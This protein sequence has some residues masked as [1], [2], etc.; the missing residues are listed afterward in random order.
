MLD[1]KKVESDN[2][3]NII[4]TLNEIEV[5]EG[6]S[7]A[8][9]DQWISCTLQVRVDQEIDGKTT[10]N[11]IPVNLYAMRH[12][13]NSTELN[14]NY[15]RI[16]DYKENLISLGSCEKGKENFASKVAI[17]ASI[18]ENTFY[19]KT[20]EEVNDW[21]LS[22][23]FVNN[24]RASDE[25][26]A[27]FQVTGVVVKKFRETNR[28]GDET[29]RLIIKLC[30]IGYAGKANV[31]E[32]CAYGTK[33]D[34]I[35]QHWNKGDTIKCAGFITMTNKIVETKE[36]TGFGDPIITRRTETRRELVIDRGSGEGLDEGHSY[37]ADDIRVAL[38]ER[39]AELVKAQAAAKEKKPV[40][41][42]N[43]DL[44]F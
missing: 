44:G 18:R 8:K 43:I 36:D 19:T 27:R 14:T 33:A 25:E 12:K 3:F 31:I 34:Y 26:G 15:D 5:K 32:F 38:D 11:I 17:T 41:A 1:I 16:V 10:E 21:R 37:D 42:S 2:Y 39:K 9:N 35:D 6:T 20:G 4:G 29:G 30:L 28:D 22:T 23:N 13:S 24:W 7:A 40:K